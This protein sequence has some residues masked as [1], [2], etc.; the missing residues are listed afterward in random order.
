MNL[1]KIIREKGSANISIDATSS[2]LQIIGVLT[3]NI[4]LMTYTN[5][6]VNEKSLDIYTYLIEKITF[7][8][9]GV[10]DN[11]KNNIFTKNDLYFKEYYI[12]RKI[13][14]YVCMT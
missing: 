14:K 7:Y 1:I 12:N 3:K 4:K 2:L 8:L 11:N 5:V 9:K 10:D 6:L 13:V